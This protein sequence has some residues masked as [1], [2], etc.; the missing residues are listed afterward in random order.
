MIK[1]GKNADAS[2]DPRKHSKDYNEQEY[3]AIY[4]YFDAMSGFAEG[5]SSTEFFAVLALRK[6]KIR[7]TEFKL[8]LAYII[9]FLFF[10]CFVVLYVYSSFLIHRL[11]LSKNWITAY[12]SYHF[13]L[14]LNLN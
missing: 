8:Q 5:F 12:C 14:Q 13:V 10:A 1:L 11:T 6:I 7:E 4:N 9:F 2:G 3:D